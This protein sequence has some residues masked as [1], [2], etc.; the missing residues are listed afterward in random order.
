MYCLIVYD[1]I[2]K[3]F[4][5][6]QIINGYYNALSL[7]EE[8]AFSIIYQKQGDI[9][10]GFELIYEYGNEPNKR[11]LARSGCYIEKSGHNYDSIKVKRKV[12]DYG[13]LYN[14]FIIEKLYKL[15]IVK[16]DPFDDHID[17]NLYRGSEFEHIE[18]KY[19]YVEEITGSHA[20]KIS[21]SSESSSS[22]N[23][24]S[25]SEDIYISSSESN[26]Q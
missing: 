1:Y 3:A 21:G 10:I 24:T 17:K 23:G 11:E 18:P 14:N 6:E 8:K 26:H 19:Y 7:M 9:E 5:I 22:D 13:Y 4:S 12:K 2:N 16:F 20:K 25:S 15:S